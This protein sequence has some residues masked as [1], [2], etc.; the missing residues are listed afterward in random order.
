[1]EDPSPPCQAFWRAE[2]VFTG[3]VVQSSYS[4][5]YQKGEGVGKWNYRDRIAHFSVDELFRGKVG[6]EV[7]VIA[8]EI[9]PT[10]ITYPNGSS[11]MKAMGESDCEYTFKEHERYLVYAQFRKTGNGSLWVGYNR[12]RPLVDATEDLKYIRALDQ[13]RPLARVYGVVKRS[14]RDLS[15]SGN[16]SP[17]SPVVNIGVTVTGQNQTYKTFTD[18]EGR[19]EVAAVPPGDYEVALLL[20][21]ELTPISPQKVNVIERGCAELNFHTESD[22]RISG[23]VFDAQGQ[24]FPRMRLD[25]AAADQRLDDPHPQVF[26]AYADGEGRYEFKSIPKGHYVLGVRLNSIREPDFP[27]PRAYYP[28]VSKPDEAKV[29]ELKEGQRI[30]GIDFVMPP[31][32]ESRT[33]EGEVVWPDGRSV[34]GASILLMITEYP[35]SFANG[36]GGT[37]D[38]IGKFSIPAF[39]GLSY[40]VNA[41]TNLENGRQMHAEPVD[42]P[43]NGDVRNVKLVVTSPMGN[44]ERCRYRYWPKKKNN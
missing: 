7:D 15:N 44:C 40:W 11:G 17:A 20:P 37:S 5:T 38:S 42:L 23:R 2:V 6:R 33:I 3:T 22:A 43:S 4:A 34:V 26:T 41:T 19:F 13:S 18:A 29:L 39:D 16:W 28:G 35:F 36:G 14:N 1:M 27:Y 31:R 8:T 24:P 12:T 21:Q 10:P 30:E 32:L 25:L 9:L